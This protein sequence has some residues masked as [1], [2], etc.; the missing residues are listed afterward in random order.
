VTGI[1]FLVDDDAA[2]R[3]SLGRLLEAAGLRVEHYASAEEFLAGYRPGEAGCLVLDVAMPGMN[4]IELADVLAARGIQ[5]PIIYLTAHGDIP[6]SVRAM[7]AGAEDFFEKPVKG[8]ALIA[9]IHEALA[10]DSRRRDDNAISSAA[11]EKLSRLT[12]R[13]REVMTLAIHGHQNKEIARRLGISH[14]TVE[15]H[16][17][18]VMRKTGTATLLEL[19][20]MATASGLLIDP[21]AQVLAPR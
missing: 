16:R 3:D 14:R 6:M 13:E 4:G 10:R 19:A 17:S 15:L 20:S 7:K 12:P 21:A 18:R 9:R 2:V 5:L 11:R 8:E 1:V